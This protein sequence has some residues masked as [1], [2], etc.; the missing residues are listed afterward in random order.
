MPPLP[1]HEQQPATC[2]QRVRRAGSALNLFLLFCAIA[3]LAAGV[4]IPD[5]NSFQIVRLKGFLIINSI[6][7]VGF[8]AWDVMYGTHAE[9][10]DGQRVQQVHAIWHSAQMHEGLRSAN[11]N[12]WAL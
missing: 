10:E 9:S 5:N 7:L 2:S 12:P 11:N 8:V 1:K 6:L 4:G 3:C